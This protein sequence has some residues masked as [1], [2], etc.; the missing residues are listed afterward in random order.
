MLQEHELGGGTTGLR[1]IE[2]KNTKNEHWSSVKLYLLVQVEELSFKN[3]GGEDGLDAEL[4]RRAGQ[5]KERKVRHV[6]AWLGARGQLL[7]WA[8]AQ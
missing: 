8:G 6:C 1:C 5:R 2:K 4:E 7:L 3:F